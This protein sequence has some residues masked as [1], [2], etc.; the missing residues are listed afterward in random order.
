MGA[1]EDAAA[2]LRRDRREHDDRSALAAAHMRNHGLAHVQT[3]AQGDVGDGVVVG[4]LYVHE[5]ERLRD[6][7]VV[8]QHIDLA[9]SLEHRLSRF[10]AVDF[11]CD[12]ARGSE[13]LRTD[14][15]SGGRR[16][17]GVEIEDGD[18]R[19]L[20]G[21]QVR[22]GLADAARRGGPRDDGNLVFQKHRSSQLSSP[23][24]VHTLR[25]RLRRSKR[26]LFSFR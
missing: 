24:G 11:F 6:S 19:A 1:A 20:R 21:E 12:V 15:A 25:R 10:L 2:A 16:R 8:D 3:A 13:M 14:V 9:K 17:V 23:I 7:G 26:R 5:L 4:R 22:N 18:A